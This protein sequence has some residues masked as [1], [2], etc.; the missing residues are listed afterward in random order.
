[1]IS[2]N[3]FKRVT[4]ELVSGL[5]RSP[6]AIAQEVIDALASL[7]LNQLNDTRF[8]LVCAHFFPIIR[9]GTDIVDRFNAFI[10]SVVS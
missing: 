2:L 6:K 4:N 8:T 7:L 5:G 3:R 10:E 9:K 1:M